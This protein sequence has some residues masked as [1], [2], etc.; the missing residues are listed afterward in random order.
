[1]ALHMYF[2]L[3]STGWLN[4]LVTVATPCLGQT[5]HTVKLAVFGAD[6][7][8]HAYLKVL[9]NDNNWQDFA[10]VN[11]EIFARVLW[12]RNFVKIKSSRNAE[13]TLS[14]THIGKSCHSRDF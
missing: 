2:H 11:S 7:Y 13:I 5:Q 9:S 10:T 14:L 3:G 6:H 1:M 8:R 12:S 4:T